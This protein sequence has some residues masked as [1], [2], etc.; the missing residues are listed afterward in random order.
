[1]QK[2]LS[3]LLLVSF[4]LLLGGCGG[5]DGDKQEPEA[6]AAAATAGIDAEV[7]AYYAANP[8]F[9]G[10]KTLADLPPT[11]F[12]PATTISRKS[13]RRRQKKVAPSMAHCRISR[14]HCAPLAPTPTMAS[15]PICWMMWA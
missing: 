15:A 11:W 3:T 14:G 8:D 7:E 1:M 13:A 6:P 2:T 4:V 5:A 10:F 12:G 9:F